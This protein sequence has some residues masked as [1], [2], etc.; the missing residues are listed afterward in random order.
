MNWLYVFLGGGIGAVLRYGIGVMFK[1]LTKSFPWATLTSNLIACMLIGF[2]FANQLRD[3]KNMWL[4]LAVGLCGGLSTF[5]AFSLES[6]ELF[7]QEN[8][9]YAL[10]NILISLVGCLACTAL[11]SKWFMP[12]S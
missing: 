6:I 8:Y 1:P 2:L 12:A 11:A 9:K 3:N 7:Q 5:S 4:F 10:L